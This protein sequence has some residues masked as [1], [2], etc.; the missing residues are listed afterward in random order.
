MK[1]YYLILVILSVVF[2]PLSSCASSFDSSA[3][4]TQIVSSYSSVSS[5]L[6]N[7]NERLSKIDTDVQNSFLIIVSLLSGSNEADNIKSKIVSITSNKSLKY[8]VK[9]KM[10]SYLI[11]DHALNLMNNRRTEVMHT[12]SSMNQSEKA[13]LSNALGALLKSSSECEPLC[14]DYKNLIS[15][16]DRVPSLNAAKCRSFLMSPQECL[17]LQTKRIGYIEDAQE[18][19]FSLKRTQY[20]IKRFALFISSILEKTH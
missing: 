13:S 14:N 11:T 18:A 15:D 8:T 7:L 16:V 3:N 4:S 10:V 1:K 9:S 19:V 5:K 17:V 2:I 6:T 12:I 20:D